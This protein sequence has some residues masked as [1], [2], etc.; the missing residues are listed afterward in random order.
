MTNL[1]PTVARATLLALALGLASCAS[2]GG[3]DSHSDFA[4]GAMPPADQAYAVAIKQ[5]QDENYDHA[6]SDFD[7]VEETY[8]YSTWS[9]HAELLAGYAQ[10]KEMDYDDAVTSLDRFIA[11]HPAD[12]ES[13]Y[14]YYL[15]SLCYYERIEDVSRDQTTTQETITALNDVIG[16][17]PDSAYAQDALIKL[18]LAN[19]RLAGHEMNIGLFYEKQHLYIAA[20]GRFQDVV[21]NY[22]TTTYAPEALERLVEVN[23]DLGLPDAAVRAASVLGYN[24]PG[25]PY[26]EHAY[27]LLKDNGLVSQAVQAQAGSG[28]TAPALPAPRHHWYWP[29]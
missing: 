18:R 24:Y 21:T 6:V 9:K 25:S 13:A 28:A 7:A 19:N 22:Q 15:K 4:T 1:A 23:L 29:F 12:E 3:Q 5:L 8:P 2:K 16:R 26:Y 17:Y 11:L 20:I 10:Y 14:A 27:N